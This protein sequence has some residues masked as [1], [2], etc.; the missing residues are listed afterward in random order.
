MRITSHRYL[1]LALAVAITAGLTTTAKAQNPWD[2]LS[3]LEVSLPDIR[4]EAAR[5]DADAQYKLAFMYYDGEEI[6]QDYEE[7]AHWFRMAA[8]QGHHDAQLYLGLMYWLGQG[9]LKDY[10]HAYAWCS[11]A[12]GKH[13][14]ALEAR[15]ALAAGMTSEQIAEA[16]KLAQQIQQI[17]QEGSPPDIHKEA[18]RGDADTQYKLAFMYYDG[19]EIPQDYEKAAHWFRMAAD[20]GH[21]DAQLYLGLMYW[22]G[23]GVLKDYVHAYA[24][25]SLAVGKHAAALEARN[26]LAA[27]MTSEQIAEAKKLARQ[28]QQ[29]IQAEK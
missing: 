16:K 9:V 1:Y 19:E 10:V 25:C 27:G 22:L 18:A 23:Q 3:I 8:D 2:N 13:V 7:A 17:I 14:A 29:N 11:L 4:K 20:Q 5:G 12:V 21:H 24:W 6:P 26:V 15:N 28:I